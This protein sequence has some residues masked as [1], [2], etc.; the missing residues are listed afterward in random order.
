MAPPK[1]PTPVPPSIVAGSTDKITPAVQGINYDGGPGVQGASQTG[2]GLQGSSNSFDAIVGETWSDA[3][4]GV[5]GRNPTKGANGGVGVYGTGGKYAG[6][7]DGDLRVNGNGE[8]TGDFNIGGNAEC[9]HDIHVAGTIKVDV[10]MVFTAAGDC[11]EEFDLLSAAGGE[12]GTVMVLDEQG[13]VEPGNRPYD[14]KVAG[15]VSGAGG[16]RPGIVLD[17]RPS[18]HPRVALALAGK[19]YCKVD[20]T[21][22]AIAVGDLLTTSPTAG[23]AMKALDSSRSFGAVIGKALARCESGCALIPVLIALQ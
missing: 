17:K 1:K 8:C 3:H 13:G 14:S 4:A 20:A 22:A 10:D 7:F 2:I 18:N 6:K 23:H 12:P 21:Y 15:V 11:A 16:Y 5:T 19:V 9:S